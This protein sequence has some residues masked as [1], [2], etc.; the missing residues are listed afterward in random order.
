MGQMG[1]LVEVVLVDILRTMKVLG[2]V[3]V[4]EMMEQ[5]VQTTN[6]L[7]LEEEAVEQAVLV[8]LIIRQ[9]PIRDMV[10]QVELVIAMI[11]KLV[12]IYGIVVAAVEAAMVDLGHTILRGVT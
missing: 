3:M 9:A 12:I 7:G 8:V 2:L 5:M 1:L 11:F 6:Q 4:L 10:E